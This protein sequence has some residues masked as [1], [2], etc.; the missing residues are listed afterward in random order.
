MTTLTPQLND[1]VLEAEEAI[2]ELE[3]LDTENRKYL[4]D[5]AQEYVASHETIDAPEFVEE[6]GC[7]EDG[8]LYVANIILDRSLEVVTDDVTEVRGE[9]LTKED[10][11]KLNELEKRLNALLSN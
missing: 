1:A 10:Q 4:L 2:E 9:S 5:K 3:S 11:E 7:Y 8:G 6:I